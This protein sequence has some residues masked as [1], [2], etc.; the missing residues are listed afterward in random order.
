VVPNVATKKPLEFA[1]V[2]LLPAT[3]NNPVDG[4]VADEKGRF[5]LKGL[6]AGEY[7]L[8]LSFRAKRNATG[9][10][11]VVIIVFAPPPMG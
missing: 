6:S 10:G 5:A 3:G 11:G 7:R 1:T 2:A 8:Q 4:T 9:R